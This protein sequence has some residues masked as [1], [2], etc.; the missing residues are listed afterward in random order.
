MR[1]SAFVVL[2]FLVPLVGCNSDTVL[3]PVGGV[4]A[5]QVRR[6]PPR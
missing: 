4:P 2:L 1:R 5:A 6:W 3:V